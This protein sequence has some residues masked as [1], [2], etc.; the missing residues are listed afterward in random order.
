MKIS[1]WV[2]GLALLCCSPALAGQRTYYIAADEVLWNYAPTGINVLTGSSLEPG[3]N[4]SGFPIVR[5]STMNTP[6]DRLRRSSRVRMPTATWGYGPPIDAEVGDSIAVV[7]KKICVGSVS[8]PWASL[9]KKLEGAP[10]RDGVPLAEKP[11]DSVAPGKATPIT[12]TCRSA[13][14][15]VPWIR[16]HPVDVST[17]IPMNSVTS[18]RAVGPIVIT[19]RGAAKKM[20]RRRRRPRSVFAL[21]ANG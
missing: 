5:S 13:P 18:I 3:R 10:Y 11:G 16:V 1:L 14:D 20:A 7:F 12:S 19:R 4:Q 15:R 2:I 6:T 17:R 8:R 21:Y 9:Q